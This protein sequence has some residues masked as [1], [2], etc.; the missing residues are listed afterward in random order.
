MK[1]KKYLTARRK[2]ASRIALVL[3]ACLLLGLSFQSLDGVKAAPIDLDELC[4]LTVMPGDT[5]KRE[6]LKEL[7]NEDVVFDL[8]QVAGA[9]EVSGYDTYAFDFGQGNPYES[10]AKLFEG[11]H[12]DYQAA[13][14]EAAGITFSKAEEGGFTRISL[15]AERVREGL[16]MGTKVENLK[17]GLYLLIAR[18]PKLTEAGD[19]VTE[20]VT[21]EGTKQLATTAY[22]QNYVY[23]FQPELIALP[24]K[25]AVSREG[26]DV[27]N[28][29]NPGE[30]IT[31]LTVTLKPE[32]GPR[33]GDLQIIKNLEGYVAG[34]AETP[35][36]A[37][38]VFQVEAYTADP[39]EDAGASLVYSNVFTTVFTGNGTKILE[40]TGV[41]PVGSYVKVTEVYSGV[42]YELKEGDSGIR[43]VTIPAPDAPVP[44]NAARVEFTN[45][46]R[47]TTTSGGVVTNHFE[48]RTQSTDDN[49]NTGWRWSQQ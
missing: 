38:F 1:D 36:P 34:A 24:T 6:D 2:R 37:S 43:E 4:S 26:Q 45:V 25:E 21:A 46:Y 11:E 19:Y 44:E 22:S 10:L 49:E 13:A 29:A 39:Q 32:R 7:T 23:T 3:A 16:K 5:E 20:I 18:S 12:I 28:T 30:W 8:Y 47:G 41:I 17:S 9:K 40:V 33:Y 48:Y 35:E 27:V 14:Q 15:D 42:S 31:D